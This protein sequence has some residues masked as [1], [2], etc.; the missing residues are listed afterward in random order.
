MTAEVLDRMERAPGEESF[1]RDWWI[2]SEGTWRY[3]GLSYW[4][5]RRP[6]TCIAF[7]APHVELYVSVVASP[8]PGHLCRVEARSAPRCTLRT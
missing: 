7:S 1:M 3:D 5:R 4:A 6:G 8:W 2:L